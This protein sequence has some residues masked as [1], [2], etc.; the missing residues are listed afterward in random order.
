MD[1]AEKYEIL[2]TEKQPSSE[3]LMRDVAAQ[4]TKVWKCGDMLEVQ[5]FPVWNTRTQ[6]A[7]ANAALHGM[8]DRR[9]INEKLRARIRREHFRR[10]VE[11]NFFAGDLM[12]TQTYDYGVI[13]YSAVD[14]RDLQRDRERFPQ[15]MA[16]ARRDMQNYIRRIRY[17]MK[18]HGKDPNTLKYIYVTEEGRE[19]RDGEQLPWTQKYH[20]HV[21][22]SGIERDAAEQLWADYHGFSN[23]KRLQPNEAGL[24]QLSAYMTKQKCTVH[25]H[26]YAMS[27]NIVI[28]QPEVS[29]RKIS[30][31]RVEKIAADVRHSGKEIFEKL[32]PGYCMAETPTVRFSEYV[33]GC[34]IYARLRRIRQAPPGIECG[35]MNRRR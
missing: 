27:K 7:A 24:A 29:D 8:K 4:R 6:K 12:L 25:S 10:I 1:S 30:R 15:D 17:W 22:M 9:Q 3:R 26:C 5:T 2:F 14:K 34:Y 18:K 31:R 16:A 19:Q 11:T 20:H 32:Y 23:S 33:S 21:L 35:R 28:P 13:D